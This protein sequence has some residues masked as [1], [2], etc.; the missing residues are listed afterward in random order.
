LQIKILIAIS[1]VTMTLFGLAGCGGGGAKS[2]T[3]VT[4]TTVS[5]GQ[6]LIDLKKALDS[7][8]ISKSDYERQRKRILEQ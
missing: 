6:Q 7:G 8:A 3:D 1:V 5:K 2:R 4:N